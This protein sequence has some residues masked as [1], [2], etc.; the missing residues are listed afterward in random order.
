V[1]LDR[2]FAQFLAQRSKNLQAN[3]KKAGRKLADCAGVH[4][5]RNAVP[6]GPSGAPSAANGVCTTAD[7]AYDR[8]LGL[9][10]SGWKGAA[11][12]GSAIS[13]DPATRGFYAWLLNARHAGF[14]T[15]VTLL[16]RESRPIAGH[17]SITVGS[18][19]ELLKIAYDE[20]EA[21]FSP[22]QILL[23]EVL[24][25]LSTTDCDTVSLVT[26]MP[27]HQPW[28][29]RPE[30]THGVLIYRKRW[31]HL[32]HA[33]RQ[34]IIRRLRATGQRFGESTAPSLHAKPVRHLIG[35]S[36]RRVKR[37]VRWFNRTRS[38]RGSGT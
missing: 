23:C 4:V 5:S 20:S 9:E 16:H 13:L 38:R 6:V 28:R 24:Q 34:S 36:V 31:R 17:F 29:P 27:W 10:T 19:R 26:N 7:E 12:T 32:A 1:D 33:L 15:E 2:D 30:S 35:S 8:F 21:K 25:S 11:G 37:L 3:L 18:R 14:A 22:G